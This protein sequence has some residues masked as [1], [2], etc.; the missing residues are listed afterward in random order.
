MKFTTPSIEF[1]I[2]TTP[3]STSPATTASS[4]SGTVGNGTASAASRSGWVCS[5]CSANVPNGPKNPTRRCPSPA[6]APEAIGAAR[7][8]AG[9][10]SPTI[11]HHGAMDEAALRALLDDVTAGRMSADDAVAALRRLPFA[12]LGDALVDHHRL[13]R[14]GMPEAVYGPGKSPE[15][16][17]RI[18]G[19]L[20]TNGRG[21]VLLTRAVRRSGE[22]RRGRQRTG[23]RAR[24]DRRL[25]IARTVANGPRPR[26]HRRDGRRSGRRRVHHDVVRPRVRPRSSGRRRGRRAA[27]PARPH[28]P[29]DVG[30]RRRRAGGHGRRIGQRHRR[31]DCGAGDRRADERRLRHVAGRGSPRCWRCTRRAPAA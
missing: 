21:A 22:G 25:P 24:T 6:M 13:L 1:S 26:R 17:A 19:E 10:L 23:P 20:L 28:R 27:P 15:Q 5:A 12:D 4:T 14:Q 2:G 31:D 16:C 11:W 30:R 3:H 9:R 29:G 8:A 18:V 7:A